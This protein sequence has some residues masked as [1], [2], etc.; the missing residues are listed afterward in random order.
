MNYLILKIL[1]DNLLDKKELKILESLKYTNKNAFNIINKNNL[2]LRITSA[3]LLKKTLEILDFDIYYFYGGDNFYTIQEEILIKYL[4]SILNNICNIG[5]LNTATYNNYKINLRD[6]SKDKL[7]P[8]KNLRLFKYKE[9]KNKIENSD[10]LLLKMALDHAENP[11]SI[12]KAREINEYY[13][14]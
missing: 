10:S 11:Y 9:F 8:F 7:N 1:T 5:L 6:Y 13:D 2:Y 3:E 12:A 4:N 14:C